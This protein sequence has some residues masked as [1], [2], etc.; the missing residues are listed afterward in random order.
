MKLTRQISNILRRKQAY[1]RIF[2]DAD[3]NLSRDGEAVLVD[4]RRF[5]RAT[6]STAVVSPISKTIDP[7][8]MALAEGRREVFNRLV[9]H[10]YV[11]ERAIFNLTDEASND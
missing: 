8:A 7:I 5:C 10:L 4:L 6:A 1:R 2:L 11:E 3:G 9:A